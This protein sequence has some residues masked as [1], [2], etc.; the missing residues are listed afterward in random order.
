[1]ISPLSDQTS[2]QKPK[3]PRSCFQ[4]SRKYPA[5][6]R[7]RPCSRLEFALP[8]DQ[9][10][11]NMAI[12]NTPDLK[13][14]TPTPIILPGPSAVSEAARSGFSKCSTRPI[15]RPSWLLHNVTREPAV[16]LPHYVFPARHIPPS[17]IRSLP[18]R[19]NLCRNGKGEQDPASVLCI[20]IIRTQDPLS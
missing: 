4:G 8:I 20:A 18:S 13:S 5:S 16:P 6:E 15:R 3:G 2:H 10:V 14:T 9:S 19:R 7:E 17:Q 1:M 11:G 12:S